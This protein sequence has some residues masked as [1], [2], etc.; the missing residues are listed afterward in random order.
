MEKKDFKKLFA[1]VAE[2]RNFSFQYN[3]W[4]VE[5]NECILTLE[6]QKSNFGNFYNLVMN[7]FIQGAFGNKY[8]KD[9][10]LIRD[11]GDIT[12]GLPYEYYVYLDLDS[13]IEIQ[14]RKRGFELLFDSFI[15]PFANK[16]LSKK[17]I[18]ELSAE[19]R[20]ILM[21]NVQKELDLLTQ[22]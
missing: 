14:D 10:N 19:R 17:G 3:Y 13:S 16:A 22:L 2:S 1:G 7:V 21:P 8:L 5:S 11:L 6:L 20:V 18:Y 4:S 12:T 9:K 15:I